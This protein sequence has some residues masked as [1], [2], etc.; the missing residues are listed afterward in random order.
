[1]YNYEWDGIGLTITTPYGTCYSQG[2]E[3]A[4]LFDELE[5]LEKDQID[6]FLS[7]YDHVCS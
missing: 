7:D 1:M 5:E 2:D 6:N 3:G 4:S